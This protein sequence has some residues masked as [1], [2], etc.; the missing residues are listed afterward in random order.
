MW[1]SIVLQRILTVRVA[2]VRRM[3]CHVIYIR[4]IQK[5]T[6]GVIHQRRPTTPYSTSSVWQTPPPPL[7]RP[8][9]IER[10]N[11]R[12]AKYIAIHGGGGGVELQYGLPK[13]RKKKVLAKKKKIWPIFFVCGQFFYSGC[14][15]NGRT[16]PIQG[17]P[18]WP[19]PNRTSLMDGP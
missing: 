6:F 1:S 2:E 5:M 11:A 4:E 8:V 14:P 18:L 17:H 7:R 13:H 9:H 3:S 19:T 12:N 10:K 15:V 16:P